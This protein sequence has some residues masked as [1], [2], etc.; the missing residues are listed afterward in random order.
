MCLGKRTSWWPLLP[1]PPRGP[2]LSTGAHRGEGIGPAHEH[3]PASDNEDSHIVLTLLLKKEGAVK[4]GHAVQAWHWVSL[5]HHKHSNTPSAPN[6]PCSELQ[7]ASVDI[8]SPAP[9][10][11]ALSLH[12][13]PSNAQSCIVTC[14]RSP[15]LLQAGPLTQ[16]PLCPQGAPPSAQA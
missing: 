10:S 2:H 9:P 3:F 15:Q 8:S 13:C 14:T 12:H 5:S 11:Q 1:A 4:E 6:P 7:G 16:V